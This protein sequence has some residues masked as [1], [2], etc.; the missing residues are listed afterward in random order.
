MFQWK[1]FEHIRL[2]NYD[3]Q[4]INISFP[5][6]LGLQFAITIIYYSPHLCVRERKKMIW[7]HLQ[8][9]WLQ[10]IFLYIQFFSLL[11]VCC[12]QVRVIIG[13]C[14]CVSVCFRTVT[15]FDW[16]WCLPLQSISVAGETGRSEWRLMSVSPGYLSETEP[17]FL[18]PVS[19]NPAR[20]QHS[21][22]SCSFLLFTHSILTV[23][24]PPEAKRDIKGKREGGRLHRNKQTGVL[25][26]EGGEKHWRRGWLFWEEEI[27]RE[28]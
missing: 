21:L 27:D 6:G 24:T 16:C 23:I 25:R 1:F 12:G 5:D 7:F 13:V 19:L 9:C 3:L 2:C 10:Y 28:Q 22:S 14:M 4:F 18:T 15:C 20:L 8:K 26:N 17:P 11:E